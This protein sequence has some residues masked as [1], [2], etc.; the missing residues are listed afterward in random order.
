MRSSQDGFT[1][2]ELIVVVVI[3]GILAAIA[4][5][6]YFDLTSNAETAANEANIKAIEAAILLEYSNRLMND[7]STDL[8]DVVTDYSA[9]PEDFFLNGEEPLTPSGGSYTVTESSGTIAVTY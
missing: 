1:L 5:P 2:M 6:K 8:A 9:A 7:S 4:V 3:I